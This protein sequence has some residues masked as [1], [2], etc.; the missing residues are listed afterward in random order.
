MI[1]LLFKLSENVGYVELY[2]YQMS[3]KVHLL[4]LE[5]LFGELCLSDHIN[6][7]GHHV[8]VAWHWSL[9][10]LSRKVREFEEIHVSE[11]WSSMVPFPL[12]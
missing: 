11:E 12:A 10:S 2:L 8:E 1:T 7:H 6:D 4:L 9:S 3:L 5:G